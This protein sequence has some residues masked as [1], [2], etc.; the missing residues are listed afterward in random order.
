MGYFKDQ[1]IWKENSTL[2]GTEQFLYKQSILSIIFTIVR[3]SPLI[4]QNL[5]HFKIYQPSE[6]QIHFYCW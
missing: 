2:P 3:P 5:R 6:L 1:K 4:I